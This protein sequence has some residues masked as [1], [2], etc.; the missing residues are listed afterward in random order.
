MARVSGI[1]RF[2]V[3]NGGQQGMG[4]HCDHSTWAMVHN[5]IGKKKNFYGYGLSINE[6]KL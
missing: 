2:Q 4:N 1:G 3:V 6:Y 5:R